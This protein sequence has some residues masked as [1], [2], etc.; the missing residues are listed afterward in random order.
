MIKANE[1]TT[2]MYLSGALDVSEE[3]PEDAQGDISDAPLEMPPKTGLNN[4]Q[5]RAWEQQAR[6]LK[7]IDER[8]E[9]ALKIR[10][11]AT[12]E[13]AER[14]RDE[15]ATAN[16]IVA[17]TGPPGCGKTFIADIA[18]G[19]AVAAGARVLLPQGSW[20]RGCETATPTLWWT[21]AMEP[22]A[23]TSPCRRHLPCSPRSIWS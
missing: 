13:E 6:A 3:P 15:A 9:T 14:L 17:I 18:I 23:C 1:H 12:E 21:H 20:L 10:D 22:S 11:A 5:R 7:T 8:R 16:S 4:E 19:K 2:G